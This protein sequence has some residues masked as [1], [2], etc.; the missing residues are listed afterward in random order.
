MLNAADFSLADFREQINTMKGACIMSSQVTPWP[1]KRYVVGPNAEGKSCVLE[2]KAANV[3]EQ[4]GHMHRADLWHT[5]EMPADNTISKDRSMDSIAR[6]PVDHG[7]LFRG[8]KFW[9]EDPDK[10]KAIETTKKTHKMLKQKYMPTDEDLERHPTM[11]RTDTIDYITCVDGEIWLMTDLDEFLMKAGDTVIITGLNHAWSNRSSGPALLS[12]CMVQAD[13]LN[14]DNLNPKVSDILRCDENGQEW[15]YKRY[16]VRPNPKGKSYTV[17][18]KITNIVEEDGNTRA[19]LWSTVEIPV[20]N[21]IPGDRA[22][23]TKNHV[24]QPNGSVSHSLKLW[25]DASDTGKTLDRT[26]ILD[27]CVCIEG[28]VWL[29][30]ETGEVLLQKGDSAVIR[31]VKHAWSNRSEA[32]C[33]LNCFSINARPLPCANSTTNC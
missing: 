13:P 1:Y 24:P 28:E 8:L 22:L 10:Q 14:L 9:P 33:L 16:V 21:N 25:P 4:P 31:G 32:P 29:M 17:S 18:D 5:A 11:H 2:D 23:G 15:D 30:T 3:V 20:D 12:V 27:C 19:I 6:E 26:D 7:T